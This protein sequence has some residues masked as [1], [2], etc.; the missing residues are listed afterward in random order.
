MDTYL[1]PSWYASK[2]DVATGVDSRGVRGTT[3]DVEGLLK[4]LPFE[5][6]KYRNSNG[7]RRDTPNVSGFVGNDFAPS[8]VPTA[9]RFDNQESLQ[10]GLSIV[11]PPKLRSG[12][13]LDLVMAVA[14]QQEANSHAV[15]PPGT[16]DA[17][18]GYS[19]KLTQAAL[20]AKTQHLID[21]GYKMDEIHR[22]IDK[23]RTD[24]IEKV[25][26]SRV[27]VNNLPSL[28]SNNGKARTVLAGY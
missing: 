2:S 28:I 12:T 27:P 23:V 10:L 19:D 21:Q 6:P 8:F 18:K 11:M 13:A 25:F 3:H 22:V 20:L 26:R 1:N 4:S 7:T 15:R 17:I 9:T 24:Q 14:S 16:L 5:K